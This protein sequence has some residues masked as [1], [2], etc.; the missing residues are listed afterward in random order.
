MNL[1]DLLPVS[2]THLDVYKRQGQDATAC[3]DF[4]PSREDENRHRDH[5]RAQ[6]DAKRQGDLHEP[7]PFVFDASRDLLGCLLYTSR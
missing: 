2:Y 5:R 3:R 4:V 6:P 7:G 1:R